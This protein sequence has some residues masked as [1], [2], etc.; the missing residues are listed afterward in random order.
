MPE[1]FDFG[2]TLLEDY[3]HLICELQEIAKELKEEN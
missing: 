1:K 3:Y 2:N